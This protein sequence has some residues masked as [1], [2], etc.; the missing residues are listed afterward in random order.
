MLNP[1]YCVYECA[2]R[3]FGECQAIPK[4]P[5]AAGLPDP[6]R[7]TA[8]PPAEVS[9]SQLR[10]RMDDPAGGVLVIDVGEPGEFRGWHIPQARNVPLRL[11]ATEGAFLPRD[12]ALV[13]VS[14][15]GRRSALAAGIMRDLGHADAS[16]LRGGMLAWEAAGFPIA[17]E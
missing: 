11:L 12:R 17:V 1:G 2:E 8:E 4:E 15:I 16:T 3:V 10:A 6:E 14:R 9:P 7:G 13:F 5:H